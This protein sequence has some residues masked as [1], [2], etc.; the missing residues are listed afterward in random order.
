MAAQRQTVCCTAPPP[1]THADEF[2]S[3]AELK[4]HIRSEH[5]ETAPR[6]AEAPTPTPSTAI[7]AN[8]AM[9]VVLNLPMGLSF[10]G[11][12]EYGFFIVGHYVAVDVGM[13]LY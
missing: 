3:S 6:A 7:N 4:E 12:Q 2:D 8:F 11:K 9:Q 13:A 5:P 10:D 1:R